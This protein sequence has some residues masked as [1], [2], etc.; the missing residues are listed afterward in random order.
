MSLRTFSVFYY[1]HVVTA[2]NNI[3]NF[4]EGS[5]EFSAELDVGSYTLTQYAA[6]VARAMTLEG[7][8]VYTVDVNRSTRVLTISAPGNFS[9]LCSTGS[10]NAS[11]AWSM[12]GF[13]T[14]SD[15]TGTNTYAANSGSGSQ[16]APQF[17]LQD[18]VDSDHWIQAADAT[19]NETANGEVEVVRFGSK[20]FFQCNIM[21]IT[22]ITQDGT[23]IQTN[24]SGVS[25]A[26]AFMNA[27]IQKAPIEYMPDID[28]RETYESLLLESTPESR[29]GVGFRLR[30]MYDKGLP[31]YFETGNL[32]F[33]VIEE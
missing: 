14:S 29:D 15:R 23:I 27:L 22:N 11:A 5:G 24:G 6:E 30:E 7:N 17:I 31:G 8:Q 13:S 25:N 3:I 4:D 1:G 9:L 2:D 12:M 28:D 33:R 21:Y 20:S 19:V 26:L 16:F 10:Q 32:K 18:H